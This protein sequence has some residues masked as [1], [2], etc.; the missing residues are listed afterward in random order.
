MGIGTVALYEEADRESL[1][2]RLADECV[3]LETAAGFMD[4]A[5]ILAI[6]GERGVDGIHP[7]YG[8]LAEE[9]AFAEACEAAGITFIG[10]PSAVLATVRNKIGALEWAST[11]GFRTVE[12]ARLSF[13]VDELPLLET[14]AEL[15]GYPVL[16]KS[17]SGGRGPG[18]RLVRSAAGLSEAVRQAQAEARATYGTRQLYLEKGILPAHQVGVQ[19]LGDR[20]GR[21]IHLGTREGSAQIGNRKLIEE[22]PA[23]CLTAAQEEALCQTAVEL[24][25]LFGYQNA[26]TVDFIVDEAGHYYFCEIKGRIQVEHPLTEMRAHVDLVREQIWLAAGEPLAST[27]DDVRPVGWAMSGRI[28]AEAP[29]KRQLLNGGMG[30]VQRLRPPG[31]PDTR[32]DTHLYDGCPMPVMYDSL[33]GKLTVWGPD[34]ASCLNRLQRALEELYLSGPPTNLPLLR[35]ILSRP[36]FVAGRYD[37]EL[38]AQPPA[39]EAADNRR[40]LAVIAAALYAGRNQMFHP[41]T[42]ERFLSEWHRESYRV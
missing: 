9:P 33:M 27:Q 24:A 19:V 32:L 8:V 31:G 6:A 30:K 40:D 26:G 38:L 15:M 17:C 10:P 22:S 20:D 23:P 35:Q 12:H 7:G 18:T 37:S 14:A 21:I 42:P 1:H 3:K 36:D 39:E 29:D 25:R 13:D 28:R 5:A 4:Q 34:R 16:V 2:V 11:A 41:S